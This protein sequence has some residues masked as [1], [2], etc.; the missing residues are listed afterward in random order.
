MASR[1]A[2]AILFCLGSWSLNAQDTS[3]AN[4]HPKMVF[5]A[6]TQAPMFVET[7]VLKP[8]HN[9]AATKMLFHDI[10]AQNPQHVFL[11]GDVVNLG[12]SS[13]Q[14]KPM[15]KYLESLRDKNIKVD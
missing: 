4:A 2:L 8:D 7:L 14:W 11:L 10:G 15:D 1:T 5:A 13:H 3:T 12:Y 6:D 9:R